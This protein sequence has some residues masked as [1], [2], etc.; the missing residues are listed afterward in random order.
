MKRVL[1]A[2]IEQ[3]I[4][5][6]LKEDT[7]HEFAVRAVQAEVEDFKTTLK[8]KRKKYKIIEENNQSDG[9]IIVKLKRQYAD[10]DCDI[11]MK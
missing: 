2:C 11:Y 1:Y 4:H 7:E 3:T 10:Y 8:R 5:F 6:R 9:S